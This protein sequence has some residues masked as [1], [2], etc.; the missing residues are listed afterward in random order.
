MKTRHI[1]ITAAAMTLVLRVGVAAQSSDASS[2]TIQ[3]SRNVTITGCLQSVDESRSKPT[4]SASPGA[5]P[6]TSNPRPSSSSSA[7]R[8]MLT[9]ATSGGANAT[10]RDSSPAAAASGSTYVLE[11]QTAELRLHVNHQVEISGHV[12]SAYTSAGSSGASGSRLNVSSVRTIS[13][14]C[15]K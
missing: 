2:G 12:S 1:V 13:A 7:N 9:G 5:R 10:K 8:F 3:Q 15:S 14:N 4:G 11:G 6:S